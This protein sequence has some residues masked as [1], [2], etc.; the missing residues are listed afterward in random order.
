[1]RVNWQDKKVVEQA[2]M[3][4]RNLSVLQ[5]NCERMVEEGVIGPLVSLLRSRD[6]KIQ[7]HAAAIV[8]TLSSANAE[9]KAL[10]VEEGGLTPLINLLRSTN[11]RV[12]EESCITLRNLSANTDNQVRACIHSVTKCHRI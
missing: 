11:K 12:Q 2:A 8:N 1:M 9:N 5:S 7:E 4:L 3:C 6:E 10:V